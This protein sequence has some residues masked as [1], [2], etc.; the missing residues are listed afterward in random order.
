MGASSSPNCSKTH[1]KKIPQDGPWPDCIRM[2]G[3]ITDYEAKSHQSTTECRYLRSCQGLPPG[4]PLLLAI[5]GYGGVIRKG[6]FSLLGRPSL[7]LR[8]GFPLLLPP[9]AGRRS[10][11]VFPP[12]STG[13]IC[14]VLSGRQGYNGLA[15]GTLL[16]P[17]A[18]LLR[19]PSSPDGASSSSS[20]SPSGE[21][22]ASSSS[23]KASGTTLC[24]R[25]SLVPGA[26]FSA[27]FSGA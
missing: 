6:L 10:F 15:P 16:G 4:Q 17:L 24:R 2:F 19:P 3:V 7:P 21:E 12:A 20:S 5:G 1:P 23:D 13:G 8:G 27:F 25:P 26:F 18:R 11:L 9:S 14:L 22:C